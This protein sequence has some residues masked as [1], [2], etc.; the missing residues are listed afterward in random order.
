MLHFY[1][2][3][4]VM[5]FTGVYTHGLMPHVFLSLPYACHMCVP[6]KLWVICTVHVHEDVYRLV[7]PCILLFTKC[8][9]F[10]VQINMCI[11]SCI[12]PL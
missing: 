10:Y 7:C 9:R 6:F 4:H 1:L 12:F 11:L 3:T 2:A 5:Y 8:V